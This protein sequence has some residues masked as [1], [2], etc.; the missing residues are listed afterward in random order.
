MFIA[1]RTGFEPA[2]GKPAR[3][4]RGITLPTP[5]LQWR[6]LGREFSPIN[7]KKRDGFQA[8]SFLRCGRGSNP[9]PPA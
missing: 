6:A 8:I 9:R 4:I 7:N 1:V 5:T 2:H 3:V